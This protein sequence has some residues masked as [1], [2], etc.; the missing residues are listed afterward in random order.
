MVNS[1][2]SIINVLYILYYYWELLI[3]YF[4]IWDIVTDYIGWFLDKAVYY[5]CLTIL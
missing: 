2:Y 1:V 3:D 4:I 5:N